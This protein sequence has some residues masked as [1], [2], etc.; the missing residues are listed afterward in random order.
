MRFMAGNG[1]KVIGVTAHSSGSLRLG[2]VGVLEHALRLLATLAK[3]HLAALALDVKES[4]L[5][6][7]EGE[8]K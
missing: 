4:F 8:L 6:S 7:I 1:S 2:W 3:P 5:A